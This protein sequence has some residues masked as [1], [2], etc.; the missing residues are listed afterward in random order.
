MT[1]IKERI[2]IEAVDN[3]TRGMRSAQNKLNAFDRTL[4]RIQTTM[5]GFVGLNI[6]SN[7]ISGIIK[8][9]DS[10]VELDAKMQNVT[11]ST[12]EFNYAQDELLELSLSTGSSLEA[13]TTLFNRINKSIKSMGGTTK[14]SVDVT[15]TLSQALKVSGASAG[16]SRSV[17]LQYSQAMASGVLR[18]EE[19]NS[20]SENG[21]RVIQA[22]SDSLGVT[23]GELRSMSKEGLLTSQVVT[24][25]LLKQ[26]E[27]IARESENIPL[28]ISRAIT[29]LETSYLKSMRSVAGV[30][31]T[32][33][34][35]INGITQH[36][37]SLLKVF[38]DLIVVTGAYLSVKIVQYIRQQIV[39]FQTLRLAKLEQIRLTKAQ[40]ASE[41]HSAIVQAQ[42]SA[43]K[44]AFALKQT[45]IE[46]AR[47]ERLVSEAKLEQQQ[48][49]IA[50]RKLQSQIREQRY[51][52]IS[53]KGYEAKNIAIAKLNALNAEY[54][55]LQTNGA[56]AT[57]ALDMANKGL[58]TTLA[59]QTGLMRKNSAA[60][61][62]SIGIMGRASIAVGLIAKGFK[63][64]S[65]AIF[66]LPGILAFVAYEI[67]TAFVP[68]D[69][70]I[71]KS[72]QRWEELNAAAEYFWRNVKNFGATDE[73]L[74]ILNNQLE[75]I[76]NKYIKAV[77]E[78]IAREQTKREEYQTTAN[79][80]V[81]SAGGSLEEISELE[82][83][84]G[85][86]LSS[87]LVREGEL[88][89]LA[90][91]SRKTNYEL[92]QKQVAEID[93]QTALKQEQASLAALEK[94]K[95]LTIEYYDAKI[96]TITEANQ[97]IADEMEL[98]E[99]HQQAIRLGLLMAQEKH[100]IEHN[101]K[102]AKAQKA[103]DLILE[104]LAEK[105][106]K[107]LIN[108]GN[109]TTD[110]LIEQS[111]R[112]YEAEK[113]QNEDRK[114][115]QEDY[116]SFISGFVDNQAS[117]YAKLTNAQIEQRNIEDKLKKASIAQ[118]KGNHAEAQELNR[119]AY[120]SAKRLAK[121]YDDIGKSAE[122][123]SLTQ[124]RGA[125]S[126]KGALE[127][128]NKSITQ[129][130][131]VYKSLSEARSKEVQ[132][133]GE[134]V[135]ATT[136]LVKTLDEDLA[137]ER[138]VEVDLDDKPI[139]SKV[140]NIDLKIKDLNQTVT[141]N[142]NEVTTKTTKTTKGDGNTPQFSSLGGSGD[143]DDPEKRTSL[144]STGGSGGSGNIVSF[145]GNRNRTS[146]SSSSSFTD[147]KKRGAS[148][149]R[150]L[151]LEEAGGRGSGELSTTAE[152]ARSTY[153]KH[154]EH[155][156]KVA[157][158]PGRGLKGM[159]TARKASVVMTTLKNILGSFSAMGGKSN[160]IVTKALDINSQ[161]YDKI[162]TRSR[163]GGIKKYVE[164][165]NRLVD[166]ERLAEMRNVILNFAEGGIVPGFG[167]GD[168]VPA[169]LTPGEGV[170]KKVH[171]DRLG[172]NFL[173]AINK[174]IIPEG[175][176]NGGIIGGGV[177]ADVDTINVNLNIGGQSA[178]G[179]F[180]KNDATMAFIDNL[181]ASEASS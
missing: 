27:T 14:T 46:V 61:A 131:D 160:D 9:S 144:S 59:V 135:N 127:L 180:P 33:A 126:V 78:V 95:Q 98:S 4:K 63:G 1:D 115:L 82:A 94:Q 70:L 45:Q 91:T 22:L 30:N 107:M 176:N 161:M 42:I 178:M 140:E 99:E 47:S 122:K 65:S 152:Q 77:D 64:L 51:L 179:S 106:S 84:A 17:I 69:I 48:L 5:M 157:A 147:D 2:V 32:I 121:S 12:E 10:I 170:I 3:T 155:W 89:K 165:I 35:G 15:R 100:Q 116:N 132:S 175:Y 85:D 41:E 44:Q 18:G 142:V 125:N 67:T 28:T 8:A 153:V 136:E 124:I 71:A 145:N 120:E 39:E 6:A 80:H 88:R 110:K 53:L 167:S 23:I 36:L 108:I 104:G 57:R 172:S 149:G 21:V 13:N 129:T 75:Q 177:G 102:I 159:N 20:I 90:L 31:S 81:K 40:Q 34:D 52:I 58:N 162:T 138:T 60:M 96:L 166:T 117:G 168:T 118:T 151:Q 101:K 97:K 55:V 171:M 133:I 25:A 73:S 119:Q 7:L 56:R 143:D 49:V 62:A 24:E 156:M 86:K 103:N 146:A 19:F 93:A 164:G 29:N 54:V 134:D 37:Q 109:K 128:V 139:L 169:M 174:G 173:N 26:S 154:L 83:S 112:I 50:E 150:P 74:E 114:S 141:V 113:Q 158:N 68:L 163:G 105:K 11:D 38:A 137:K 16:E 130:N 76:E 123:G 72:I 66:G 79:S 148:G 87:S 181:K 111:K 92:F 43:R